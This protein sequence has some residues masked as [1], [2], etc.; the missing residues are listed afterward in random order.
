MRKFISVYQGYKWAYDYDR[1]GS[2][3][4]FLHFNPTF[5]RFGAAT[6]IDKMG[7]KHTVDLD[8]VVF[9]VQEK[10][11]LFDKLMHEALSQGDVALAKMRIFVM[12]DMYLSRYQKGLYDRDYGVVHNA[13]FIGFRPIHIDMGKITY[14]ERMKAKRYYKAD[15]ELV[16]AR[17]NKWLKKEY[18]KYSEVLSQAIKER[19]ESL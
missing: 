17:L 12:L 11:E 10:G 6:L 4:V 8:Q 14:D 9:I 13:A 16:V 7:R 5:G 18:P 19:M 2:G 15:L 1:E 3:L